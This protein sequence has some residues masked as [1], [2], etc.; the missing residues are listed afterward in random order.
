MTQE[1]DKP[2]QQSLAQ[3]IDERVE[4]QQALA[5]MLVRTDEAGNKALVIPAELSAKYNVLAP[6]AVLTQQA[7]MFQPGF[8]VVTL[9]V[10][11]DFYTMD[12]MNRAPGNLSDADVAF[13][14]RVARAHG[15]D[16]NWNGAATNKW[17][18]TVSILKGGL[19]KLQDAG[20]VRFGLPGEGGVDAKEQ[21]VVTLRFGD[22][23]RTFNSRA[24]F[25]KAVGAARR[26]DG[27][28]KTYVAESEWDPDIAALEAQ[29]AAEKDTYA[30][31]DLKKLNKAAD[32][33]IKSFKFR[34]AMAKSK[35]HNQIIRDA[36]A[37]PQKLEPFDAAKPFFIVSYDFTPD[38]G[39]SNE[40]LG[41]M[42][43]IEMPQQEAAA[44]A[45]VEVESIPDDV[46]VDAEVPDD[47]LEAE[48]EIIEH[49]DA[50]T[51]SVDRSTGE[52]SVCE[53]EVVEAEIVDEE[54]EHMS[55]LG[56]QKLKGTN[57]KGSTIAEVW[58]AK[59][60]EWFDAACAMWANGGREQ[61]PELADDLNAIIEYRGLRKKRES[62]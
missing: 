13:L 5:Q 46:G 22:K 25:Y 53:P 47:V 32:H 23:E 35:A 1:N 59:G 7:R 18:K 17:P 4:G 24:F 16:K 36:L 21:V 30:D 12:K 40:L 38:E 34:R 6:T 10:A 56:A 58:E 14:D 44:P 9:D 31:T 20:A 62:A 48:Y 55:T 33:F 52:F 51:V 41:A 15:I 2:Q 37:I 60:V 27:T 45:T 50:G 39:T 61:H 29:M 3:R 42:Y 26:A 54:L 11:T 43:G 28:L 8:T 57:M 49:D 19:R